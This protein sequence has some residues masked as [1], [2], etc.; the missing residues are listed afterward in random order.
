MLKPVRQSVPWEILP[1]GVRIWNAFKDVANSNQVS[2]SAKILIEE[3]F[4]YL[5]EFKP[6][7]EYLSY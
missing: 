1:Q 7:I 4:K 6:D 2:K 5:E 3:R